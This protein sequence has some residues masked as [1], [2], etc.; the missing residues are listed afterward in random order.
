[1][2]AALPTW[3]YLSYTNKKIANIIRFLEATRL[4]NATRGGST[5]YRNSEFEK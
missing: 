3:L 1:V 2:S 4:S 5:I